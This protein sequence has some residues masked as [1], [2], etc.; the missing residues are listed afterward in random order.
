MLHV[1]SFPESH[2]GTNICA[3]FS[4]MMQKGHIDRESVHLVVRDNASN[5]VKAMEDVGFHHLGCFAHTL[6][7]IVHDAVF[8]QRSV[9]DTLAVCRRIVG[10]FKD[11]PLAYSK[12]K[13]IQKNLGI[14]E[15]TFNFKQDVTTRWNTCSSLHMLLSIQEQKVALAAYS[16]ENNIP[17]LT[18]N[19]LDLTNKLIT[20]LIPIE[21]ITQSISC[22]NSCV[23]VIIPFVRALC[24]HLE[25]NDVTDGGVRTMKQVMLNSLNTQYRD[26][27]SN[28]FLVLASILDSCFKNRC[29]SGPS[30]SRAQAKVLLSSQVD[31]GISLEEQNSL[32]EEPVKKRP[33]TTIV[34]CLSEIL[35]ESQTEDIEFNSSTSLVERYLAEPLL[36]FSSGVCFTWWSENKNRYPK[37][38]RLARKYLSSP[39]TSVP[40]ERVFSSAGYIYCEKRNRLNPD[41]AEQLL[42]IKGDF[43]FTNNYDF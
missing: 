11:S 13:R 8:T 39:P 31:T 16:T 33:K 1:Q 5:M 29:F 25:N 24:K 36:P 15:H 26:V 12:I 21:D 28:D 34:K 17:Q 40:S 38:S 35:E 27:E 20:L 14:P 30:V 10:H 37:L 22:R 3:I 42:F 32:S 19:Q 2:T 41:K 18:S 23:S 4:V 6:Q 43:D 9:I 7:L